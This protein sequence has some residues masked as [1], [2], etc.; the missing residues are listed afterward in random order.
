MSDL[1]DNSPLYSDILFA[2]SGQLKLGYQL[3]FWDTL[4]VGLQNELE[5]FVLFPQ[6][7][8]VKDHFQDLAEDEGVDPEDLSLDF[9]VFE[10][11]NR[12]TGFA[13]LE[14]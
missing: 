13:R 10:V 9:G 1:G 12:F 14:F 8:G 11:L 3:R 7:I 6:G 4:V 5:L 2:V